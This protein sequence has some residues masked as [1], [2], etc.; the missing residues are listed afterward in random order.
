MIPRG[1]RRDWAPGT[2][3]KWRIAKRPP[4]PTLARVRARHGFQ[5]RLMDF[6]EHHASWFRESTP[7]T[8]NAS[9]IV[10]S[11]FPL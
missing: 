1:P 4:E 3:M 10:L 2:R 5:L 8:A 9:G 11:L 7:M 6:P